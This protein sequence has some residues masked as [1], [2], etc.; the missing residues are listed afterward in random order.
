MKSW[1]YYPSNLA[2]EH[3]VDDGYETFTADLKVSA[4]TYLYGD[5]ADGNRGVYVTDR[6]IEVLEVRNSDGEIIPCTPEMEETLA[7][8]V[9]EKGEDLE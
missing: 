6:E 7:E 2:F 3:L 8:I 1:T 9:R 5:D 4:C